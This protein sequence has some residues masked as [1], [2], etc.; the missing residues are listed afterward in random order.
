MNCCGN[1]RRT[2]DDLVVLVDAIIINKV[3]I[4]TPSQQLQGVTHLVIQSPLWD[5]TAVRIIVSELNPSTI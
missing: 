1:D 4:E 3:T 5:G 2:C